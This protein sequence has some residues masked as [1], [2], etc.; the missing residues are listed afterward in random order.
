MRK[1]LLTSFAILAVSYATTVRGEE[2]KTIAQVSRSKQQ[3]TSQVWPN[4]PITRC[5]PMRY[6]PMASMHCSVKRLFRASRG[7]VKRVFRA[8]RGSR[9]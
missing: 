5:P 3:G 8:S 2:A 4:G 6:L 1:V 9:G 7:S